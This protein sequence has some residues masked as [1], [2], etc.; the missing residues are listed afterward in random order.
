M[1]ERKLDAYR[2]IQKLTSS[3]RELEASV[4]TQ[5]AVKLKQCRDNWGFENQ[6]SLLHAAL[7]Y[8]QKIWTI[9]QADLIGAQNPLPKDLKL[10]LLKLSGFV[11]KQTFICMAH[12]S[13]DRLT[14][15]ININLRIAEGLGKPPA[16]KGKPTTVGKGKTIV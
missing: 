16:D 11:D 14:P 6:E 4:L 9:F 10:S 12:P 13:P 8:N 2:R 15:L 7:K 1:D 5:A 3:P